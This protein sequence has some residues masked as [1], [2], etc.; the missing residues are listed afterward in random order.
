MAKN[1]PLF[2][3]ARWGV[4]WGEHLHLFAWLL[5]F[6]GGPAAV[7]TLIV[8]LVKLPQPWNYIAAGGFGLLTLSIL[9]FIASAIVGGQEAR[10]AAAL[11]IVNA[12]PVIDLATPNSP[13][14]TLLTIRND[15]PIAMFRAEGQI[16]RPRG[17]SNDVNRAPYPIEWVGWGQRENQIPQGVSENLRVASHDVNRNTQPAMGELRIRRPPQLGQDVVA[18]SARWVCQ[19]DETLPEFEL[20]IRILAGGYRDPVVRR[21]TLRLQSMWG[22][23][24]LV[25]LG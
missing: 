13:G 16:L 1:S 24:E 12:A 15:G 3:W 9:M 18:D 11:G 25:A 21:Y 4:S 2:R 10:Q 19:H 7:W 20:E 14:D 22:R 17:G 8:A 23:A 6:I 5:S